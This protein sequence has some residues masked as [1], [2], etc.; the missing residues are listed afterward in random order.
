MLTLTAGQAS[1]IGQAETL[2]ADHEPDA[3]IA[4]KCYD[5]D[6]DGG[7]NLKRGAVQS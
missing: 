4:D 5:S 1:D 3:V 7:A 2:L 6:A